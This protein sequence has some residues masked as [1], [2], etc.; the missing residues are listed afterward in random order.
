MK[1]DNIKSNTRF[2]NYNSIENVKPVEKDFSFKSF[3]TNAIDTVDNAEK[4]SNAIDKQL[5]AGNIDNIHSAMIASQK[6][7]I[8]LN[9]AMQVRTKVLDAYKEL[10]RLQI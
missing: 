9:F 4:V 5:A 7:E 3:L 2:L 6:A 1:V 8:T 10:T